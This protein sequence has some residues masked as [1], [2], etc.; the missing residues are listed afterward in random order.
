MRRKLVKDYMVELDESLEKSDNAEKCR[1][2]TLVE[3]NYEAYYQHGNFWVENELFPKDQNNSIW[4]VQATINPLNSR[5]GSGTA[6]QTNTYNQ[7][8]GISL[9]SFDRDVL[10]GEIVNINVTGFIKTKNCLHNQFCF[11]AQVMVP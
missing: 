10:P 9:T 1:G 7:G 4:L 6:I 8:M 3:W 2:N 11:I 5:A